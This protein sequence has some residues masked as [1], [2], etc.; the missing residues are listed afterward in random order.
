[1]SGENLI[2]FIEFSS[3]TNFSLSPLHSN[4]TQL[5]LNWLLN[6]WAIIARK[7]FRPLFIAMKCNMDANNGS[8]FESDL[9]FKVKLFLKWKENTRPP[10]GNGE[11]NCKAQWH[12]ESNFFC[13]YKTATAFFLSRLIASVEKKH[14]KPSVIEHHDGNKV[15]KRTELRTCHNMTH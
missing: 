15:T 2:K 7:T 4:S 3:S 10:R 1:M 9:S 14:A 12:N 8:N 6:D 5:C 11:M 13:T